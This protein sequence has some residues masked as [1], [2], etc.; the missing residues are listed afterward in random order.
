M[1]SKTKIRT[2]VDG[3]SKTFLRKKQGAPRKD[4]ELKKIR[5]NMSLSKQ[6]YRIAK[7]KAKRLGISVSAFYDLAGTLYDIQ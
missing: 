6:G 1:A 3:T 5:K 7:E 2:F 4:D